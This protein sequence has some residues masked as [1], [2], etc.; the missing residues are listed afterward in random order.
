MG[1]IIEIFRHYSDMTPGSFVEVKAASVV[2]HYRMS[3]PEFG[4]WK[5]NQLVAD[6]SA[7]LTNLPTKIQHGKKIVEASSMQINKGAV[8]AAFMRQGNDPAVLCAGDDET[9]E[10]MF[11]EGERK[12][13]SVKIGDG[14][15]VARFRSPDPP[16]FRGFLQSLLDARRRR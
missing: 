12:L 4:G 8:M 15:T 3:D 5:A 13:F 14:I 16:A 6:L 1:K 9:D 11:R 10:S 7:I 2:W